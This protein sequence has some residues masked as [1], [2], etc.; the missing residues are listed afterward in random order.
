MDHDN[1]VRPEF[2]GRPVTA[3]LVPAISQVFLV[4]DGFDSDAKGD[5]RRAVVAGVI[6]ENHVIDD[7]E[8]DLA[9]GL[10]E[11][12]FRVVGGHHHDDHFTVHHN[13][14]RA[15]RRIIRWRFRILFLFQT[16]NDHQGPSS[17][18]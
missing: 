18:A 7:L 6:D 3:L 2:Q 9:V 8:R 16:G 12:I 17:I 13:L 14:S 5:F 11:R 1:D 4:D 15:F 10:L